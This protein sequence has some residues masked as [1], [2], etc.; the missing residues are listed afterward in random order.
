M[1]WSGYFSMSWLY[2]TLMVIYTFSIISV[3]GVILSENR[4][5]VKSLAWVTVLVLFPLAG[6]II[7]I[8]FGRSFKNKRMISRRNKRRLKKREPS[9][10]NG[11]ANI[12]AL[13]TES[14]QQILL[15]RSLCGA[16]LYPG[17]EVEIFT[18]G[19][20][21][22]ESLLNDLRG[23]K[24]YIHLQYYIFEDDKIGCEVREILTER[25]RAGVKVRVIYDHVG[26]ISVKKRFFREM[27]DAGVQVYPFFRV[28]FPPFGSRINW[29]N[30]RKIVII[31]GKTGYIGGMN[32]ADRYIDGG[33]FTVWR[34][35]HIRL[36]GPAVASLQYSFAVDWTFMGHPLLEESAAYTVAENPEAALV[37]NVPSG[38]MS[39]WSNIAHLF[40]KAINNAKKLV[41]IQTPYFLPTE[42]LLKAL[43]GAALSNVDVRIMIPRRSDSVLLRYASYSYILECLQAGIKFYF[44]EPGMLHCKTMIVDDEFSSAGSTNF[45]FRSFEHNFESNLFIYSKNVNE[46]M[47]AIFTEDLKQCTRIRKTDW[48]NRPRFE[49]MKESVIRLLSPIL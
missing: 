37:Q 27:A 14:R 8:F 1:D 16:M 35:T 22:F 18:N 43:Q 13:S 44:Y 46:R 47:R 41:Y 36:T 23:A 4:N 45:D 29:R 40:S 21:K 30:H 6:L 38:P 39:Q 26:S 17:N 10:R 34:D 48:S 12:S 42:N 28:A 19:K 25:A 33:K 15:A 5:P 31:D 7:Y 3:I 2:W 20:D 49:K 9:I 32:I 24:E 11:G